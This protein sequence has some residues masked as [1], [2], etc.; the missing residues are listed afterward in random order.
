MNPS[1]IDLEADLGLKSMIVTS[2][3]ESRRLWEMKVAM[4]KT[5]VSHDSHLQWGDI[6]SKIGILL[7]LSLF[8]RGIGS[9]H[10][11]LILNGTYG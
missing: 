9:D 4:G 11:P 7:R 2:I 1:V 6:N 8:L 5:T 3:C 10:H